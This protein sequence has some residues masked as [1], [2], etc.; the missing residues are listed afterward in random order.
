M[1]IETAR[2][3]QRFP[4]HTK[5]K[6]CLFLLRLF[7]DDGFTAAHVL[8]FDQQRRKGSHYEFTTGTRFSLI[9]WKEEGWG[10]VK[11]SY[12]CR[13]LQ[14]AS[15]FYQQF[16]GILGDTFDSTNT[17]TDLQLNPLYRQPSNFQ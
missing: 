10:K 2:N 6:M 16:T 14:T 13:K 8:P 5:W 1:I 9:E 17:R 4:M 3:K 11:R 15:R 12:K 7:I